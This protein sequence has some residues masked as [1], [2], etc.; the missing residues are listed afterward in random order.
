MT[1]EE[2]RI[3]RAAQLAFETFASEHGYADE[4][5]R[6]QRPERQARWRRIASAVLGFAEP[7][8]EVKRLESQL[9]GLRRAY[10]HACEQRDKYQR[11][12][13]EWRDVAQ[14]DT[15]RSDTAWLVSEVGREHI[16]RCEIEQCDT[17]STVLGVEEKLQVLDATD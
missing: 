16:R 12:T 7:S 4:L 15:F 13:I 10:D 1:V 9:A 14:N 11:R 8:E 5:W 6:H 2:D 3:E 17:C